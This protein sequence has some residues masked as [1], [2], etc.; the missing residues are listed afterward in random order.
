MLVLRSQSALVWH[1]LCEKDM[2]ENSGWESWFCLGWAKS[3]MAVNVTLDGSRCTFRSLPPT[4]LKKS[5]QLFKGKWLLENLSVLFLPAIAL[6]T[7]ES[8]QLCQFW[9]I[10]VFGTNPKLQWYTCS[11]YLNTTTFTKV[12]YSQTLITTVALITVQYTL[13]LS[14]CYCLLQVP[15]DGSSCCLQAWIGV[16]LCFESIEDHLKLSV[17]L[18]I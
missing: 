9:I 17:S 12:S 13:F 5:L 18:F 1:C 2:N 10:W 8:F 14:T 11:S 6:M 15:A 3:R 16:Y 7:S 4:R